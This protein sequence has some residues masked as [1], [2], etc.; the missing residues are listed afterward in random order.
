M[1]KKIMLCAQ[2][3]DDYKAAGIQAKKSGNAMETMTTCAECR[4]RRLCGLCEI[5]K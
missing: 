2:C 3:R 4:R 5:G 1:K